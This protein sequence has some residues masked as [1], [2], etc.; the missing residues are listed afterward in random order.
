MVD[1]RRRRARNTE[2]RT[3]SILESAPEAVVIMN[4]RGLIGYWNTEAERIFGWSREEAIGRSMA[5]TIIPPRYRD[6]HKHGLKKFLDTGEGP[7]LNTRIEINALHRDG[8]EFPVELTIA[9]AKLM[10]AWTFSAFIRDISER[11]RAEGALQQSEEHLRLLLNS[12]A[13]AIYGVDLQGNCTF[14]NSAFVRLLGYHSTEDFFGKDMHAMIHH[15]RRDGSPYPFGECSIYEAFRQGKG[16][17]VTDDVFWR[18]DG[19]SFPVEYWSYPI[20]R[21]DEVVGA[22]VTFLDIT[23]RKQA[24]A[25]LEERTRLASLSAE[26]G[27]I[28]TDA[29]PPRQGLQRSAEAF[30]EYFDAAFACV[31]TSNE[32]S[33]ELVLD[34]YAGIYTRVKG[35]EAPLPVRQSKIEYFARRGEPYLS[36]NVADDPD[37]IDPEWAKREGIVGFAGYPLTVEGE[38]LGAVAAFTRKPLTRSNVGALASSSTQLAQF[39]RRKRGEE[40]LLKAREIAEAASRSKSE[41]LTNMS[42]ELRTA[43]NGIISIAA[44]A[45]HTGLTAE[46][47]EYLSVVKTSAES[48]LKIIDDILDFTK[49]EAPK[50]ELHS[51]GFDLRDHIAAT[52][53]APVIPASKNLGLVCDFAPD[54]PRR[55]IGHPAFLRTILIS[56]LS[57]AVTFTARGEVRVQVQK[58]SEEA[59]DAVLQFSINNTGCGILPEKQQLILEPFNQGASSLGQSGGLGLGLAIVSHLVA[60]MQG[61]IWVQSQVGT[62]S[63]FHFT[64]RFRL[65]NQP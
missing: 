44:L 32:Q 60:M 57:S 43:L 1:L 38:F 18:A 3:R 16:T 49:I 17:H 19:T 7:I 40:Q 46:E 2:Q 11:K 13:Q 41:L 31:W 53:K 59:G 24:Q 8:H 52:L 61:R 51:T 48:L 4:A 63:I 27:L 9:P 15:T 5:E 39:I 55:V 23:E 20:R 58:L 14:C 34:A 50:L 35:F 10:G 33:S 28:L 26:I 54:V 21:Q 42:H 25:A 45:P 36:N 29:G 12:T 65:Q 47:R 6:A 56:L 22:A 37:L 30:V 64:S 62:G